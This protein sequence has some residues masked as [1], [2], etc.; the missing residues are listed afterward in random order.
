ML[1]HSLCDGSHEYINR[2]FPEASFDKA[3]LLS[4]YSNTKALAPL[5]WL[6]LLA[7]P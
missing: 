5:A 4:S 1:Q 7:L 6:A 3:T 2:P